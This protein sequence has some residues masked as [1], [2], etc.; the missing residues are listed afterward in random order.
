MDIAYIMSI[1][2]IQEVYPTNHYVFV[3]KELRHIHMTLIQI[4]EKAPL[5]DGQT[6][7]EIEKIQLIQCKTVYEPAE[8][9]FLML[10]TIKQLSDIGY[11]DFSGKKVLELGTGVGLIGLWIAINAPTIPKYVVTTDISSQ[12]I[13]CAHNNAELNS[14]TNV[15]MLCGDLFSVFGRK[16]KF[17]FIIFNPPYVP[18]TTDISKKS[19]DWEER[20]WDGG[21]DGRKLID[22]FLHSFPDYIKDTGI[23]LILHSS[24]NQIEKAKK[25]SNS[26]GFKSKVKGQVSLPWEKLLVLEIKR[27]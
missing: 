18:S 4:K 11:L 15:N 7:L 25:S 6:P 14:A 8:D 13:R 26:L 1:F 16:A 10:D 22:Q 23:V 19:L 27:N 3:K 24:L 12:A 20:A 21:V 9:T 5:L 17:D 2:S